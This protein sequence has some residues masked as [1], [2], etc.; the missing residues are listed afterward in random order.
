MWILNKSWESFMTIVFDAVVK[1]CGENNLCPNRIKRTNYKEIAEIWR[2]DTMGRNLR[3]TKGMIKTNKWK[4]KNQLVCMRL[5]FVL[6]ASH[7]AII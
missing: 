7:P 6:H 3:N 5:Y 2:E 1:I 4:V